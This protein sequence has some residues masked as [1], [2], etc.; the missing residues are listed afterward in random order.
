MLESESRNQEFQKEIKR[1]QQRNEELEKERQQLSLVLDLAPGL[2][3]IHDSEGLILYANQRACDLHG[4]KREEFMKLNLHDLNTP[5]SARLIEQRIPWILK[6]GTASFEAMHIRK[7]GSTFP[8]IVNARL[9]NWGDSQ[10]LLSVSTDISVIKQK[11]KE[12]QF[13]NILLSTQQDVSPDGILVVDEKGKILSFNRRLIEMW[14]IPSDVIESKSDERALQSILSKLVDPEEFLAQV[15]FL[16]ENIREMSREEIILKDGR[17]FDRYS[18]PLFGNDGSY[19]GRIWNFRDITVRKHAEEALRQSEEKFRLLFESSVDPILILD[20]SNQINDCNEAAVKILGAASKAELTGKSSPSFTPEYQ[21]DGRLSSGKGME[22]FQKVL[23]SGSASSEWTH[24]RPDGSEFIVDASMTRIPIGERNVFLVHWRDIT[25]SKLA[26][27]ERER[28]I[29]D[30]QTA[31]SEV[32][33]LSG[34]LPI[35][36]SCKKIRDDKGYWNQIEGY[37]Q[38]HSDAMFSHGICP[39]CMKKLYPEY[40]DDVKNEKK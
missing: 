15:K 21:H 1:L 14:G 36:S 3:I 26:A 29:E 4:Y 34:L 33:A 28:L 40:A 24:V 32:R 39:D 6:E 10:A 16:Y 20:E 18:A 25:K 35:C 38:E 11:E 31:L 7:D 9:T 22:M 2:V 8:L 19:Y 12:L 23:E 13:R 27:L 17:V 37:I 5:K 30:L